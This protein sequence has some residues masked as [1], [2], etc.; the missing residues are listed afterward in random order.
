MYSSVAHTYLF[1]YINNNAQSCPFCVTTYPGS[2][3][4]QKQA[5]S[6]GNAPLPPSLSPPPSLSLPSLSPTLLF[7]C[8]ETSLTTRLVCYGRTS[9]LHWKW[10]CMALVPR[11]TLFSIAS[12]LYHHGL[13]G[14]Q[15]LVPYSTQKQRGTAWEHTL[16][17]VGIDVTH[18]IKYSLPPSLSPTLFYILR[19]IKNCTSWEPPP[20][21]LPLP[22]KPWERGYFCVPL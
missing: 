8:A 20:P 14:L 15:L 3:C 16:L 5:A 11:P 10:D 4:V 22:C 12:C 13:T 17:E 9:Q 7:L 21:S 19:V 18:V 1:S 6:P 2:S